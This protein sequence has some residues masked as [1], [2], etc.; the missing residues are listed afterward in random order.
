MGNKNFSIFLW[1]LCCWYSH[2]LPKYPPKEGC[3][4]LDPQLGADSRA[5]FLY[6]VADGVLCYTPYKVYCDAPDRIDC[7]TSD[8]KY[9]EISA[10]VDFDWRWASRLMASGLY[11][12][13]KSLNM[14]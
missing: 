4:P 6:T 11:I 12:L 1:Y 13:P 3:T 9:C 2:S 14:H 8:R 5:T 10:G 7:G